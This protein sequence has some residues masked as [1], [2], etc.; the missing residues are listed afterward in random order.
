VITAVGPKSASFFD[1][2]QSMGVF[3]G[4]VEVTHP[5]FH[6]TCD[7]L[8]VYMVKEGE[9]SATAPKAASKTASQLAAE[10]A[11]GAP[12]DSSAALP[13]GS[14]IRQ[15]IAKGRKVVVQKPSET[16][17]MQI[18][19]CRHATY[20]GATGEMIMRDWPQVQ[21]GTNLILATSATTV[22]TIL[23]DGKLK[24][25][26][27]T[28]TKIIQEADKPGKAP[29]AASATTPQTQGAQQ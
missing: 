14:S 4:D 24:T 15:A 5:Q 13:E 2:S 7:T 10:G 9:K 16:G 6:L 27:P 25:A 20:V 18:G 23:N 19:V 29:A 3:T 17:E 28:T 12:G 21:K 1:G 8:E 22:I 26:G 11:A